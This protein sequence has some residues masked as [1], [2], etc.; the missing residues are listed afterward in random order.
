MT[1]KGFTFV[2]HIILALLIAILVRMALP[3]LGLEKLE[4]LALTP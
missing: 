4:H 2:E 1:A 3:T